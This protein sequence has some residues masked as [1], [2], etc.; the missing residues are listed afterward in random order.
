M[1]RDAYGALVK[2][3]HKKKIPMRI[4]QV[5][6][7][8]FK[9][10]IFDEV[11]IG[12]RNRRLVLTTHMA[13]TDPRAG[14]RLPHDILVPD[15]AKLQRIHQPHFMYKLVPMM[16]SNIESFALLQAICNS[17]NSP[18]TIEDRC[19][20]HGL[21]MRFAIV[22]THRELVK[23]ELLQCPVL[24]AAQI[25]NIKLGNFP[26]PGVEFDGAL[27]KRGRVPASSTGDTSSSSSSSNSASEAG[28]GDGIKPV[29]SSAA[30]KNGKKGVI[31][32]SLAGLS[33]LSATSAAFSS[34]TS[35]LSSTST[36]PNGSSSSAAASASSSS[37]G[38]VSSAALCTRVDYLTDADLNKR[39]IMDHF[40]RSGT[41]WKLGSNGYLFQL[42]RE[43]RERLH[44]VGVTN[45]IIQGRSDLLARARQHQIHIYEKVG[46]NLYAY[47]KP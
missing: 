4:L 25:V 5:S 6:G 11:F 27:V 42:V 40:F 24:S 1:Q 33:G 10:W 22:S 39:I 21:T 17:K 38:Y 15:F 23:S 16:C 3:K 14:P 34:C 46:E 19:D 13:G 37:S 18:F 36:S 30:T 12:Y 2:K 28:G 26:I 7:E 29:L 35:S 45:P 43:T 31:S 8:V 44:I 20:T 41:Y 9:E 47:A 32:P